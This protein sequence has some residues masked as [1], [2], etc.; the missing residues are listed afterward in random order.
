MRILLNYILKTE[1]YKSLLESV[2]SDLVNAGPRPEASPAR[3]PDN[4]VSLVEPQSV[5][6]PALPPVRPASPAPVEDGDLIH[7]ASSPDVDLL[8]R[9]LRLVVSPV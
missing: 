2:E 4:P 5:Q 6:S 8:G 9:V 3:H 7:P 1:K